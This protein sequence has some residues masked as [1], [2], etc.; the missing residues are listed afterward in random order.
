[1][2]NFI[3]PNKDDPAAVSS[4]RAKNI[5]GARD[6]FE[7]YDTDS[8]IDEEARRETAYMIEQDRRGRNQEMGTDYPQNVEGVRRTAE[9]ADYAAKCGRTDKHGAHQDPNVGFCVGNKGERIVEKR[10]AVD[11]KWLEDHGYTIDPEGVAR[12]PE[13]PTYEDDQEFYSMYPEERPKQGARRTAVATGP[14]PQGSFVYDAQ[15][16][17]DLGYKEGYRYALL[18]TPGKP[19]P[20]AVSSSATLGEKY[21]SQYVAG[22][23]SGL[24][25]GIATLDPASQASWQQAVT[26]AISVAAAKNPGGEGLGWIDAEEGRPKRDPDDRSTPEWTEG[27]EKGYDEHPTKTAKDFSQSERDKDASTQQAIASRRTSTGLN[28]PD[29]GEYSVYDQDGHGPFNALELVN[30]LREEHGAR[31]TDTPD[32][33]DR[34]GGQKQSAALPQ[35]ELADMDDAVSNPLVWGDGV[36]PPSVDG[37]GASDVA[38]VPTPGSS[39]ADYPTPGGDQEAA[40]GDGEPAEKWDGQKAAAFRATVQ[41]NLRRESAEYGD[42]GPHQAD[43]QDRLAKHREDTDN[44]RHCKSARTRSGDPEAECGPH[45]DSIRNQYAT[46]PAS[47]NYWAS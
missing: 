40:E 9:E 18:W 21:N 30:H 14:N 4:E 35:L 1:M 47:E 16:V 41:A 31:F 27:Y 25:D 8:N 39:V 3:E 15:R 24:S 11:D 44:C 19:V 13:D 20:A 33:P 36:A 23:R 45:R 10:S 17:V 38:S 6:D 5:T 7:L 43:W 37:N 34:P 32:T 29:K 42:T 2:D 46:H 12:G 28:E 22:Y 26:N